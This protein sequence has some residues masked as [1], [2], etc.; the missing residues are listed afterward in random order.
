MKNP[1]EP[2]VATDPR[3]ALSLQSIAARLNAPM[4]VEQAIG[5]YRTLA[6]RNPLASQLHSFIC[7]CRPESYVPA[8]IF[9][10][11]LQYP[12]VRDT[13]NLDLQRRFAGTY[14]IK[15][16]CGATVFGFTWDYYV[17]DFTRRDGSW[18]KD[19]IAI[20]QKYVKPGDT[21][22]DIGANIGC[23]A[24]VLATLVGPTGE[25][26]AFEPASFLFRVLEQMRSFNKFEQVR[27]H[28]VALSELNGSLVLSLSESNPGG[29]SIQSTSSGNAEGDDDTH[30]T[31]EAKRA[32][33]FL[34]GDNGQGLPLK[35]LSLIK[36][37]V[38]GGEG[39]VL[40]GASEVLKR[41]RPVIL[42]E[43]SPNVIRTRGHD[44]VE[45]LEN[46]RELNMSLEVVGASDFHLRTTRELVEQIEQK[47][48]VCD[49]LCVPK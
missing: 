42:M 48:G 36:M 8:A 27:L 15:M 47:L 31:I 29:N 1:E 26:H 23:H 21:V 34:L 16:E 22:L 13:L 49:V 17:S 43:F 6:W 14:P 32:D 18:E 20:F 33:D 44:P 7:S 4:T 24:A 38:E 45:M 5:A 2:D 11:L 35:S 39:G 41:F 3:A 28:N 37:D 30:Q 19:H 10:N 9:L 46:I 12:E 25:V 40:K